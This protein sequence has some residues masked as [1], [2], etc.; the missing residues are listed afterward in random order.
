MPPTHTCTVRH[1]PTLQEFL[2]AASRG[3]NQRLRYFLEQG[4]DV[5]SSDYGAVLFVVLHQYYN[6]P[7]T[8]FAVLSS[9]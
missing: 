7:N 4:F 3:N 6:H 9:Q 8:A 1:P 2:N 5:D